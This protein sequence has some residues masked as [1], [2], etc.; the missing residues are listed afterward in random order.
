MTIPY[1][2]IYRVRY[3]KRN[4]P[5]ILQKLVDSYSKG[6]IFLS[7]PELSNVNPIPSITITNTI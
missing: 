4:R 3:S 5:I 6:E 7:Y 1:I 2:R